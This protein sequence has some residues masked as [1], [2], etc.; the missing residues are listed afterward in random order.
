MK[1]LAVLSP[2]LVAFQAWARKTFRDILKWQGNTFSRWVPFTDETFVYH[3]ILSEE[4]GL[5]QDW[6]SIIELP[7]HEPAWS[8]PA[9]AELQSRCEARRR[10]GRRLARAE[11]LNLPSG[12]PVTRRR[13]KPLHLRHEYQFGSHA[14][15]SKQEPSAPES[16][17]K[18][19]K[20]P[21]HY[22]PHRRVPPLPS[23]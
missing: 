20:R 22:K 19:A 17:P 1:H 14:S 16:A 12:R 11:D 9:Y 3:C 6:D 13:G 5:A 23:K 21:R 15:T 8:L 18:S 2:N 7:G 4:A 10:A